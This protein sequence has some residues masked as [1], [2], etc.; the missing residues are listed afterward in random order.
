MGKCGQLGSAGHQP[1]LADGPHLGLWTWDYVFCLFGSCLAYLDLMGIRA[2]E[3]SEAW[4]PVK[5]VARTL[6]FVVTGHHR[7]EK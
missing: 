3:I 5:K 1:P 6:T 7:V 4:V 2:L